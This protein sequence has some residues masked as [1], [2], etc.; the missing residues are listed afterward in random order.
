[1]VEQCIKSIVKIKWCCYEYYICGTYRKKSSKLCT[2]HTLKVEELEKAVLKAIKLH[3]EMLVDTEKIL[4]QINRS[5]T[6]K[7]ANEN[8]KNIK[9]AKAKEI[10]RISN[11]KRCLYEDWKSEYI[12]KEEYLNYKQKYEQDIDKIKEIIINLDKQKEKQ[13]EIINGNSL[14]IENFKN[15]KNITELD[16]EIITELI[17]YIEVH[18]N[19]KITIHFKF[20]NELNKIIEH[21][22]EENKASIFEKVKEA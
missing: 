22:D 13:E 5:N 11:L 14:W 16:R 1:M 20:M 12:T 3:I 7:F 18:E 10:E 15:H 8:M 19:K 6:K 21:I 9:Q 17:D 4:E 2:K